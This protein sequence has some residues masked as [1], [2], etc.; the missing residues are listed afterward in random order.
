M[1]VEMYDALGAYDGGNRITNVSARARVSGGDGVL[2]AGLVVAGNT[3]CRLLARA[4]GPTLSSLGVTGVLADPA[5]ELYAAGASA[6][7]ASNDDWA[8]VQSTIQGEGLFRRVGAFD[9]PIGSRDSVIVTR[10]QPGAYTLVA[11]GKGAA[12][13]QALIEIYLI[14]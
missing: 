11:Q 2:I 8:S 13:G 5:L 3:T 4:V 10:I 7:I 6:P 12:Q 14:D 9:L 1:L